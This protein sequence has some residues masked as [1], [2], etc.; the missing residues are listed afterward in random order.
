MIVLE[1]KKVDMKGVSPA[2]KHT[3]NILATV[4]AGAVAFVFFAYGFSYRSLPFIVSE[5]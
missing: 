5:V 2:L 3:V 1:S 4:L